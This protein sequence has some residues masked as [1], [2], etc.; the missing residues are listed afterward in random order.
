[1]P[2]GAVQPHRAQPF[3]V[4][5]D[6]ERRFEPLDLDLRGP[7]VGVLAQAVSQHLAVDAIQDL[8]HVGFVDTDDRF[9]IE[10]DP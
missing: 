8:A 5:V 4:V 1:M 6:E 7:Q 10:R 9:A 3:A 2:P